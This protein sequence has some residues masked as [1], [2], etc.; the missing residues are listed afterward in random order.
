LVWVGWAQIWTIE[1]V[2]RTPGL[3]GPF[4]GAK[5][6]VRGVCMWGGRMVVATSCN[7]LYEFAVADP[8]SHEPPRI[9]RQ[10]VDASAGFIAAMD[11]HPGG[12][13]CSPL[14]RSGGTGPAAD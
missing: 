1:M 12:R 11:V 7:E 3:G 14:S 5:A 4:G 8:A 13:P 10:L 2:E 6:S 9:V